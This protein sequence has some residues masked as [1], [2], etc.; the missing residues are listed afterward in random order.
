MLWTPLNFHHRRPSHAGC[1]CGYANPKRHPDYRTTSSTS[2]E[3]VRR[4]SAAARLLWT[5]LNFHHRRPS[6]RRLLVWLRQPQETSRLP[7]NKLNLTRISAPRV[8]R[9]ALALDTLRLSPPS[10]LPRR[11]LVWLRQPQETSRL[12]YNKLNLT[13]IS[14][15]RVRRRALALDTLKLS[16]S[17]S[18]PRRLLVWLRQPQETS[19]LPYNKLNL[20]RISAPRVRRRALALDTLRL[21]PP[22]S[23]PTQAAG[24]ATPTPRD[25][26]TTVQHA[27]PHKNQCAARPPPRA[28]FGHP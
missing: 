13:R 1:W 20:T 15:P 14:A 17:P 24:V 25:I 16:P 9:R 2:Q 11:L 12:P 18:L 22:S 3:S 4:A 19:R 23:L 5:P 7:Y 21:S 26:P 8:R 28:C 27:Q 6:Q 10:S